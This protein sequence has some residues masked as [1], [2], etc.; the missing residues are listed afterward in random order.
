VGLKDVLCIICRSAS[1]WSA[2]SY[3]WNQNSIPKFSLACESENSH[4]QSPRDWGS[5]WEKDK[6]SGQAHLTS[7]K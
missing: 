6:G 4:I 2:L 1:S 5:Y 3:L 7:Y